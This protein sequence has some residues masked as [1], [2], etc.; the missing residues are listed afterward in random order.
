MMNVLSIQAGEDLIAPFIRTVE[1]VFPSVFLSG[2]SNF[3]LIA[4]KGALDLSTMVQ[5]LRKSGGSPVV[6]QVVDQVVP[7][8]RVAVAGPQWPI[9]TDDLNDVEF[10]TFRMFYG[11]Y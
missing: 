1:S 3:I 6:R 10:R 5:T 7:G 11:K 4:S 9:F 2:H 8:L